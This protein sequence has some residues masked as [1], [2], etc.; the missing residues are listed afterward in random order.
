MLRRPAEEPR[1]V[2]YSR[3]KLKDQRFV[4]VIHRFLNFKHNKHITDDKHRRY[5]L[6]C[7]NKEQRTTAGCVSITLTIAQNLNMAKKK[8]RLWRQPKTS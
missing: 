7:Y 6:F 2:V 1:D 5:T 8:K 4:L 3:L